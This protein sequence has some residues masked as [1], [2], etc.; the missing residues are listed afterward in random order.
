MF[1]VSAP[2]SCKA[3]SHSAV[4]QALCFLAWLFL[5]IF[6][7]SCC[8]RRRRNAWVDEELGTLGADQFALS[9]GAWRSQLFSFGVFGVGGN[10]Q[11]GSQ[12]TLLIL[13]SNSNF[14]PRW[15]FG[16]NWARID[17]WVHLLSS[18]DLLTLQTLLNRGEKSNNSIE[19]KVKSGHRFVVTLS[20]RPYIFIQTVPQR[21]LPKGNCRPIYNSERANVSILCLLYRFDYCPGCFSWRTWVLKFKWNRQMVIA[22]SL[23]VCSKQIASVLCVHWGRVTRKVVSLSL[24][25]GH[26]DFALMPLR[27]H[28]GDWT[29][30]AIKAKSLPKV[31]PLRAECSVL[32]TRWSFDRHH[33]VIASVAFVSA[34]LTT[35][36]FI[37]LSQASLQTWLHSKMFVSLSLR[38]YCLCLLTLPACLF[39]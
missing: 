20:D 31:L 14:E 21:G 25:R 8:D 15:T 1:A 11:F 32:S 5:F 6:C 34:T 22:H 10:L 9:F 17:L 39:N 27:R 23:L 2:S 18:R 3:K 4:L 19:N 24:A 36:N 28:W 35:A 29:G 30:Q 38:H 33:S 16:L 26:I 37:F 12:Y 13:S 7:F